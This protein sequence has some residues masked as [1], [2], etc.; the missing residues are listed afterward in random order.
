[1]EVAFQYSFKRR[2]AGR[3][4][5]FDDVPAALLESISST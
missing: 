3:P 2:D 1:M 4:C 5:V